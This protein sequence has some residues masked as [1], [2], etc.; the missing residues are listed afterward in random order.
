MPPRDTLRALDDIR[1]GE[2]ASSMIRNLILFQLIRY[3]RV[4]LGSGMK[5]K[6]KLIVSTKEQ[7]V[8]L[9]YEELRLVKGP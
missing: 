7:V 9:S 1:N 8:T 5:I 6:L 3:L 4:L 2:I